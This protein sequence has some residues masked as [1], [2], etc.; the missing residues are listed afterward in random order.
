VSKQARVF[1]NNIFSLFI[2]H[3]AGPSKHLK[4]EG[5][6]KNI[7]NIDYCHNTVLYE[8]LWSRNYDLSR[9]YLEPFLKHFQCNTSIVGHTPVNGIELNGNQLVVSSSFGL[10]KKAYVELDL[11]TEINNG[12]DLLKM[13]KYLNKSHS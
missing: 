6:I 10:G 12:Q 5:D 9:N 7:S 1:T 3:H 13:I 2:D 4:S 8:M 11:E